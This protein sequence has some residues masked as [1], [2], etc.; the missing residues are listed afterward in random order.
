MCDDEQKISLHLKRVVNLVIHGNMKIT[1]STVEVTL[2]ELIY[3]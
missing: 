3:G 2:D 1:Q